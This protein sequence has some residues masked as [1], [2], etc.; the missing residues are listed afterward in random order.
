MP[1][2]RQQLGEVVGHVV[3]ALDVPNDELLL[4][5]AILQPMQSHVAR[6]GEL[7]LDGLLGKAD[8]NLI[9]TVNDSGGLG[10]PY[11]KAPRA[12]DMSRDSVDASAFARIQ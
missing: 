1:V 9:V 7:G 4:G 6:L 11:P 8:S 2:H 10:I 5:H 12:H 3:D